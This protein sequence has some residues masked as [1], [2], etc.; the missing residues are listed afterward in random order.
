MPL[1]FS[2]RRKGHDAAPRLALTLKCHFL[3]HCSVTPPPLR[4]KT[5]SSVYIGAASDAGKR[6][7][8]RNVSVTKR[9]LQMFAG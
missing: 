3:A 1:I 9:T 4:R 8:R 6:S 2:V 5:N 7:R